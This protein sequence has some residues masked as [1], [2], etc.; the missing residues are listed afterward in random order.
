MVDVNALLRA[1]LLTSGNI[2]GAVQGVFA[3]DLPEGFDPKSGPGIQIVSRGGKSNPEIPDIAVKNMQVRVWADVEKYQLANQVYG[4]VSDLIQGQS[5]ITVP[6]VGY[7]IS[8]V[9]TISSQDVTDP[10]TGWAT[11][12]AFYQIAARTL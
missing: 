12:I 8:C 7:V 1:W 9:E 11:V 6:G 10:D 5:N 2:Q 3:G 4:S